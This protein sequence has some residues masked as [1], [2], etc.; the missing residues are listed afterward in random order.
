MSLKHNAASPLLAICALAILSFTA[1]AQAPPTDRGAA[2][3]TAAGT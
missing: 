1:L 3:V 2:T